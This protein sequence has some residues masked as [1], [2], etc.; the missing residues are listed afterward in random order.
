MSIGACPV[1]GSS[2]I[3]EFY[4]QLVDHGYEAG[5]EN[6]AAQMRTLLQLGMVARPRARTFPLDRERFGPLRWLYDRVIPVNLRDSS[7]FTM[8]RES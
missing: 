8:T 7:T 2:R 1:F 6:R 5:S 4:E 3:T